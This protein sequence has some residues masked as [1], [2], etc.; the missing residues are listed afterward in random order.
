[1]RQ[2]RWQPIK[3]W[4]GHEEMFCKEP[5]TWRH[6]GHK[7]EK[8]PQSSL[9]ADHEARHSA[10]NLMLRLLWHEAM[11]LATN[12]LL[13]RPWREEFLQG[14]CYSKTPLH[15]AM[16]LAPISLF[17]AGCERGSFSAKSVNDYSISNLCFWQDGCCS[18][19]ARSHA[20]LPGELKLPYPGLTEAIFT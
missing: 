5:N 12:C 9:W 2:G 14:T 13:G 8:W 10:C 4:T 16:E 20:C 18:V 1:M 6:L 19:V 17:W 3:L 11:E 7:A 15:E